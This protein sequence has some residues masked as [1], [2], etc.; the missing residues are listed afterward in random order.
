MIKKLLVVFAAAALIS[1]ACFTV[2]GIM[3]IPAAWGPQ[4][5]GANGPPWANGNW[6]NG[7][8]A[9][10]EVTRNLPF[11]GSD[12][13]DIYYPAEITV[14]QGPEARFTV[15]G[16]Q[17][18]L[19]QLRLEGGALT[20][21][22]YAGGWRPGRRWGPRY[23]GRLQIEIVSPNTYEFNLS[24]AQKLT[25]RN[26]DQDRLILHV[27]GTA[28]VQGQGKARRLEAHVSGAGHLDLEELTVDDAEVSFSGA[29]D[30]QIDARK[31]SEVQISGVGHVRLKCRPSFADVQKSGLGNVDY[32]PDCGALPPPAAPTP[33]A[34]PAQPAPP[35]PPAA[36]APKSK[37]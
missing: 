3:G 25:L 17:Y 7:R 18:L 19:D 21:D 37:I 32:G 11:T 2:L 24:G 33:P 20:T 30:A 9:G 14:T 8:N 34:T 5:F 13:L 31:S 22:N 29:G 1:M 16:P 10:P 23:N 28:D 12:R 4:G 27:S 35:T 36:P 26:F 15:T 6:G